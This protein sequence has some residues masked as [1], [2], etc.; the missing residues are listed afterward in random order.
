M[1]PRELIRQIEADGEVQDQLTARLLAA[2]KSY[3]AASE[4][5]AADF[6]NLLSRAADLRAERCG[7]IV[8]AAMF[9]H[10][11]DTEHTLRGFPLRPVR[12]K[13]LLN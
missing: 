13:E 4:E 3:A 6:E 9:C 5:V 7:L 12:E 10:E 2:L 1:T 8:E 11:R